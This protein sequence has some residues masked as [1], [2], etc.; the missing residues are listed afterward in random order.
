VAFAVRA[1]VRLVSRSK[2]EEMAVMAVVS[3][4][5]YVVSAGARD[6][7]AF[8]AVRVVSMVF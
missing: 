5:S 3:K 1:R 8:T 6:K 4:A 7:R 2:R